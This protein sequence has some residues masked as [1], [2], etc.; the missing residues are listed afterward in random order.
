MDLKLLCVF[1]GYSVIIQYMYTIC[2]GQVRVISFSI[3]SEYFRVF[4]TASFSGQGM[5]N[6]GLEIGPQSR[7][8]LRT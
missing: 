4:E 2:N 8:F 5:A 1:V 6:L 7:G 3:T